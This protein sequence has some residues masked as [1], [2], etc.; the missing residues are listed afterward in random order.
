MTERDPGALALDRLFDFYEYHPDSGT[1]RVYVRALRGYAPAEI[2]AA[3]ERAKATRKFRP[4]PC[5]LVDD[6]AACRR[7]AVAA[8]PPHTPCAACETSPGWISIVDD[9]GVAR[10]TR[11]AC[12]DEY[13]AQ[14]AVVRAPRT[15]LRVVSGAASD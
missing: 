2:D 5:E 15:P 14:R 13:R 9:K 3:C 10:L 1:V 8:L 6:A 12:W 7:E 11:C 4:K